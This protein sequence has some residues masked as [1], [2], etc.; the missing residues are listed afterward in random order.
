MASGKKP[1]SQR[2]QMLIDGAWGSSEGIAIANFL[3]SVGHRLAIYEFYHWVDANPQRAPYLKDWL[4]QYRPNL[5]V[6]YK[7]Q[8]RVSE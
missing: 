6:W 7:A 5:Y 8:K 4:K 2:A 1:V 3:A